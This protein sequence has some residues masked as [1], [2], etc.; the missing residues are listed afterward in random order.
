MS[1]RDVFTGWKTRD[2]LDP[3]WTAWSKVSLTWPEPGRV[4]GSAG[5]GQYVDHRIEELLP[6]APPTLPQAVR[7]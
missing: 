3:A 7:S 1:S 6:F 4:A 5:A 2:D